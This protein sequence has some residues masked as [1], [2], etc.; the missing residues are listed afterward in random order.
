[1]SQF[2]PR[3]TEC[4]PASGLASPPATPPASPP[5]SHAARALLVAR[6]VT[7]RALAGLA[8][9][10][11]LSQPARAFETRATSAWVYDMTT[12]TVLLE[13]NADVPLPPASMSK[14]MTLN[15]LFEALQDGRV[16][17][18]RPFRRLVAGQGMAGSTMF[19]NETDRPTVEDLIH[20]IIVQCRAMMPASWSPRGWPAPRRTS[21]RR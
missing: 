2:P 16:S 21:P 18:D 17:L 9:A 12:D 15:M 13:K 14:L 5:A 4:R 3:R 1:M 6:A 19:L 7:L 11:I 10:L 20:G 8:I